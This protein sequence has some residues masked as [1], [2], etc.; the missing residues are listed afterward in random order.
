[1]TK[2]K[3]QVGSGARVSSRPP[4]SGTEEGHARLA[5]T[6]PGRLH[7]PSQNAGGNVMIP[8]VT[9][10]A[11]MIISV[12]ARHQL[13]VTAQLPGL[14]DACRGFPSSLSFI[15]CVGKKYLIPSWVPLDFNSCGL[16]AI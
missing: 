2:V 1:M 15:S 10:N 4:G 3:E 16:Y 8:G 14:S 11:S 6:L 9:F 7:I 5:P 13:S 12:S